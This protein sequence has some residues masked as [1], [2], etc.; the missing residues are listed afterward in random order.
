[1]KQAFDAID[2]CEASIRHIMTQFPNNR[3]VTRQY[4]RF[5]EEILSDHELADD[6]IQKSRLLNRNIPVTKD[7]AHEWGTYAFPNLPESA[8]AANE[9]LIG[10]ESSWAGDTSETMEPEAADDV[11]DDSQVIAQHIKE[12]TFPAIHWSIIIQVGLFVVLHLILFFAYLPY[13]V[14]L[15]GRAVEPLHVFH[16]QAKLGTEAYVIAGLC[17]QVLYTRMNRDDGI[18]VQPPPPTYSKPPQSMGGRWNIENQLMYWSRE[19][20]GTLQSMNG[21]R[22]FESPISYIAHAKH[23]M[24]DQIHSFEYFEQG[25]VTTQVGWLPL[26]MVNVLAQQ[27]ALLEIATERNFT[28]ADINTAAYLNVMQNVPLICSIIEQ[29]L[30]D[31]MLYDQAYC[32]PW[33]RRTP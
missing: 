20:T 12:L 17:Q 23:L 25:E 31:L 11:Q 5:A 3:F 1:M 4:A 24:F 18:V 7:I 2:Q 33:I 14:D 10:A 6:M 15:E 9:A 26:G 8:A 29:I 32:I 27:S 22:D 28:A 30:K 19:A 13:S 21:F 16:D